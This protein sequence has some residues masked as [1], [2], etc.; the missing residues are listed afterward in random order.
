LLFFGESIALGRQPLFSSKAVATTC[1]TTRNAKKLV[2][3]PFDYRQA[4]MIDKPSHNPLD[5]QVATI[6]QFSTALRMVE[7]GRMIA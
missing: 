2:T 7:F 5:T 1:N 4:G 3:R 6:C